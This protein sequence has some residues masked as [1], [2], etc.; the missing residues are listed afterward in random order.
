MHPLLQMGQHQALPVPVQVV[1]AASGLKLE[2]ASPLS[3]FHKQMD[4]RIVAK[5]LKM[6]HTFHCSANCLLIYDVS[7]AEFNLYAETLFNQAL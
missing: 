5:G 1:L 7:C 2:T 4:L 6:P 3:R